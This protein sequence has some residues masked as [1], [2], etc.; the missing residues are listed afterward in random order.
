MPLLVPPAWIQVVP[1]PNSLATV[2]AQ[3][4]WSVSDR[5]ALLVVGADE[6]PLLPGNALPPG[7]SYN[8]LDLLPLFDRALVRFPTV[9]AV[10]SPTMRLY[11][12]PR[13]PAGMA[14]ALRDI[15][16]E[17]Y[18][19]LLLASLTG[20]LRA[21]AVSPQGVLLAALDERQ[22]RWL[23]GIAPETVSFRIPQAKDRALTN[24]D[25][26][27][28]RLRIRRTL[29]LT[30]T[31]QTEGADSYALTGLPTVPT[32]TRAFPLLEPAPPLDTEAE[33]LGRKLVPARLKLTE[34]EPTS[35]ALDAHVTLMG[36]TTV[37]ELVARMARATQLTLVVHADLA[38][39]RVLSRGASAR[40]GD[41]LAALCR[42]LNGTVRRLDDGRETVYLLV[43]DLP[44][45]AARRERATQ[46]YLQLQGPIE[47]ER[48]QL[49]AL[50]AGARRRLIRGRE[51]VL[52]PRSEQDAP[53]AL[54][55]QA[56][57]FETQGVGLTELTAPLRQELETLHKERVAFTEQFGGAVPRRPTHV[58]ATQKLVLELVLP[59][60]EAIAPLT[61]LDSSS[62]RVDQ[63]LPEPLP[64]LTV[65]TS[66]PTRAWMV[67][68][69]LEEKPRTALVAL[70]KS[71]GLTELR[72]PVPL[73]AEPEKALT[74]LARDAKKANLG[75]VPVLS[76][77]APESEKARRDRDARGLSRAEWALL[78]PFAELATAVF[79]VDA[80]A[81]EAVD[82]PAFAQRVARLAAL[83]GVTGIGLE[84]LVAPGYPD[85]DPEDWPIWTGGYDPHRRVVFVKAHQLD[86]A[87]LVAPTPFSHLLPGFKPDERRE[88]WDKDL[89]ARRD[90]LFTRLDNA[91]KPL[92]VPLSLGVGR[93]GQSGH[94]ER[95]RG[96]FV[97][98]EV[99]F[100]EG[101]ERLPLVPRTAQPGLL[102]I[103]GLAYRARITALDA[104]LDSLL[105]EESRLR[106]WLDTEL[107]AVLRPNPDHPDVWQGFV[108]DL[109]D[110]PL[111]EALTL[112]EKAFAAKD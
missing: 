31:A 67:A 44:T 76:P 50:A 54:W 106:D 99:R 59:D 22:R 43:E 6:T 96:S 23:A 70:A 25:R 49:T 19:L 33:L 61:E 100:D 20:G 40:A 24:A 107:Q 110:R 8:P 77:L 45:A 78:S 15:N 30:A 74:A 94:W 104:D 82:A 16:P 13:N 105:D 66:C 53:E 86:P 87:D 83:P 58:A 10:V 3:L 75:V 28:L 11:D 14:R 21:Q 17:P 80:V 71:R 39:K 69:P 52:L 102:H 63:P 90:A 7:K 95:W 88:P 109:T 9:T 1:A 64:A 12:P 84:S 42:G 97:R 48:R 47:Q 46:D 56:E 41:V 5:G 65:P 29:E 101:G 37:G 38:G 35:P 72:V 108:L 73:G 112:L 89:L 4:A 92:A 91:L 85:V 79:P 55:K 26:P 98:D 2:W 34:L 51:L 57:S 111:S 27:E 62:L 60:V 103:R 36:A 93:L 81:P 32:V 68:L 18:T